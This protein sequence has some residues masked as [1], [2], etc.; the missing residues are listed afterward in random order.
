M[1]L[2]CQTHNFIYHTTYLSNDLTIASRFVQWYQVRLNVCRITKSPE[3]NNRYFLLYCIYD[4]ILYSRLSVLFPS[5]LYGALVTDNNIKIQRLALS[6]VRS[7]PSGRALVAPNGKRWDLSSL[8]V[9]Y[10]LSNMKI[11]AIH[12][13]NDLRFSGS[14]IEQEHPWRERLSH[15]PG[16]CSL[17]WPQSFYTHRRN[18]ARLPGTLAEQTKQTTPMFGVEKSMKEVKTYSLVVNLLEI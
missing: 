11:L 5:E 4:F 16:G 15:G 12:Q 13:Q 17:L 14:W 2:G 9:G 8:N 3:Y 6:D 10:F 1:S 18:I 7:I